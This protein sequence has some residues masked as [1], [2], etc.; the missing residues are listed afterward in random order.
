MWKKLLT[1][2]LGMFL[3]ETILIQP[4]VAK[5]PTRPIEIVCLFTAGGATDVLARLIGGTASKYLGQP[6]VVVNKP[7]ASGSIAAADVINSPPDGYKLAIL[8]TTYFG[9]TIKSQKIPFDPSH[10]APLASFL[11]YQT[12]LGVRGDSP[13]KTL[14][15]LLT[16][17]RKNPG[18]IRWV[19]AGRG[20]MTHIQ[21]LLLFK[22]AGVQTIDLPQPG[23]PE[24]VSGILG[25][26][27]DAAVQSYGNFI[28]LVKT[29][30]MRYL[31]FFR[32]QRY[33]RDPN[34]PCSTELGFPEPAKITVS[35]GLF[36][37]KD[38]SE[39]IKK[40]LMDAFKW[41]YEQPEFK[42]GADNLGEEAKF[43]GPEYIKESIKRAE[44]I[45]VPIIKE[46]GLYV[47]K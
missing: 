20:S 41:T 45:C 7:G 15:D 31:T 27:V 35:W 28:D 3:V 30:K 36:V 12:G 13:W 18:K 32:D 24:I 37:H 1:F 21:G 39:E 2:I 22:K 16:Y 9:L 33:T 47:G 8:S 23:L 44:E 11:E 6:M 25:G 17:G 42:K 10:L 26:H 19:H 38:T 43:G 46:L 5:Y 40:T 4:A 14:D 34:I 29:G